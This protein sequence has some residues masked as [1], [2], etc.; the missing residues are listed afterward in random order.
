MKALTVAI[1][2]YNRA[3]ALLSALRALT[4]QRDAATPFEIVVV[5]NNSTDETCSIVQ[6]FGAAVRYVFEGRQGLSF[7]R[8]AAIE[9]ASG[10]IIAFTDDDVE[11]APGWAAV[12]MHAF[13]SHRDVDCVGGRVLPRWQEPPPSWLTRVH[14]APLALQDHGEAPLTFDAAAPLCLVGAN[15]AFRRSVFA[16][17][18]PFSPAVQRVKDG[19]GSTEDHELLLRLYAAG[20]RALYVPDLLVTTGIPADRLTR[21]YHRRW[22]RGHGRFH[23]VMRAPDVERT[24]RGR[25]LGVP[26]HLF[27]AAASDAAAWLK[28]KMRGDADGAF[29][30]ETRLWFFSGFLRERAWSARR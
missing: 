1:C 24:R 17:I 26:A 13:A 10:G 18:G 15:V 27:R 16:D 23:A 30:R 8:N 12:L 4:A 14:W 5:D 29:A 19:I 6:S 21:S 25:V 3:G 7:A 22:H 9:A 20:R 28:L 2:T 11:V